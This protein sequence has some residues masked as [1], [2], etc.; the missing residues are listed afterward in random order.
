MK[1]TATLKSL[2]RKWDRATFVLILTLAHA[3]LLV[4]VLAWDGARQDRQASMAT[5]RFQRV[6]GGMGL[7]ASIRPKWCFVNFDP[8]IEHCTCSEQPLAGGYCYCPE[9]SGTVSWFFVLDPQKWD[10]Q[11]VGQ[12]GGQ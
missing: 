11:D 4:L 9:H 3:G 10:E 8:R 7:G 1:R 5:R 6:V 2:R 12:G